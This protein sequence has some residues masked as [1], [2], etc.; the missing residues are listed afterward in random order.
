[1]L[2]EAAI[3]GAVSQQWEQRGSGEFVSRQSDR[4]PGVKGSE[5]IAA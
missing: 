5:A 4:R 2:V 1:M 3:N